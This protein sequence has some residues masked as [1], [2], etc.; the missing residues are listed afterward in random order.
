MP[1]QDEKSNL[2]YVLAIDLG[3]GGPKVGLVDQEG[4]IKA[5]ASNNLPIYFLPDGGAE[6]DP[7]EW[8]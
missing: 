8:W 7:E 1:T 4:R 5:S 3:T 6:Q 2:K